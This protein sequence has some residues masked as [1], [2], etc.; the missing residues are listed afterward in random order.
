MQSETLDFLLKPT[1]FQPILTFYSSGRSKPETFLPL[2]KPDINM[3]STTGICY[4]DKIAPGC[5]QKKTLPHDPTPP[6]LNFML[7]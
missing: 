2:F 3:Q 4:N 1:A 6:V 7:N 5:L